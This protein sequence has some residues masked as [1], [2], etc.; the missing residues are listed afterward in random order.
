MNATLA[1]LRERPKRAADI[2]DKVDTWLLESGAP[3]IFV[4]AKPGAFPTVEASIDWMR[5]NRARLD[6]ILVEFGTIVFRGFPFRTASD[7]D[8]FTVL[9]DRYKEGYVAGASP[10]STVVG[11]VME[12][13]RLAPHF[14]IWM[15]QEMSY[16]PNYPSR[17]AF[18]AR[19]VPEKGGATLI[20]DMC[21]FT[22][23]LPGK[24]KGLIEEHGVR[25]VRNYGP[26]GKG[27]HV[28]RHL[29]DKPWN[30]GFG[31]DDKAEVEAICK[32]KG[33]QPIWNDDGSLTVVTMTHGFS[34][35][36]VTGER[37]YRS[38]LHTNYR[39]YMHFGDNNP[40]WDEAR[41]HQAFHTGYMLGNNVPL[42]REESA[43]I[44]DLI[45]DL[46]VRWQWRDGDIMLVDNLQVAHG[47]DPFVGER[48]TLV[49]LF[50]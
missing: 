24:L 48:E 45:D 13:T 8:S 2:D 41:T 46:I 11:N 43:E 35:H 10:R 33:I 16:M 5:S 50:A 18:F 37:I 31:V 26:A 47:R 3:P 38:N 34:T 25:G 12:A 20:A 4:E 44:E 32:G 36:P 14:L 19:K 17:I 21:E 27:T 42:T 28:A 1:A 30:E 29:D 49:A 7:F 22:R 6:E 9:Y 39:T 15:H 23:R 40:E